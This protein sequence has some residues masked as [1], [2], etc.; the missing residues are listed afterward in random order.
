M[1]GLKLL[2][3]F[4]VSFS[5]MGCATPFEPDSQTEPYNEL[6][7]GYSDERIDQNTA[8]VNFHG[9]KY[10]K[11]QTVYSY[12]LVRAAQVTIANGYDYFIITSTT[13]SPTDMSVRTSDTYS[14]TANPAKASPTAI[15]TSRYQSYSTHPSRT[16]TGPHFLRCKGYVGPHSLSAVIKMFNGQIPPG[17][18]NAYYARDAVAH[19]GPSTY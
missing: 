11:I 15:R 12:L 14:Y 4:T 9:N 10:T 1:K 8:I 7:G 3:M 16:Y 13:L 19:L 18:P 2:L 6:M 5:L 17:V